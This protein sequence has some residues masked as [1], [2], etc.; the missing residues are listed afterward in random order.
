[1]SID[2]Y[3]NS[4]TFFT[5]DCNKAATFTSPLTI[6]IEFKK[7]CIDNDYQKFEEV[8]KGQQFYNGKGCTFNCIFQ[9]YFC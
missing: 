5:L 7:D 8:L 9:C 2:T 3:P 1:M 4:K 6:D